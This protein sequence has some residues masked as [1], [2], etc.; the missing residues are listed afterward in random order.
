MGVNYRVDFMSLSFVDPRL[1]MT[2]LQ[3]IRLRD[4][5]TSVFDNC[6][7]FPEHRI[8]ITIKILVFSAI[9]LEGKFENQDFNQYFFHAKS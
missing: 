2:M 4:N 9:D 6:R 3:M 1:S 7:D 8:M 5:L